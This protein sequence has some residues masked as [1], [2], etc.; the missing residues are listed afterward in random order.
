L[1]P[2][3]D[4][5]VSASGVRATLDWL[6]FELNQAADPKFREGQKWFF[7]EPVDPYGVRTVHL[8]RI[9][10]ELYKRVKGWKA[11][12]RNRLCTEMWKNGKLEESAAV[13]HLYRHFARECHECEFRLFER[14]L[15]RYVHTWAHCDGLST[16]LF[17]ASLRNEP[18]LISELADWTRSPNR[19]RRRAAAVSLLQEAKSG[20]NLEAILDIADR[21]A[22]DRDDMVEKGVGWLLKEAYPK[23]PAA[24]VR[25]LRQNRAR[26]SRTTLRYAA[27][28]MTPARRALVL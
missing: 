19:W 7:K 13:C 28:K 24:V 27:E 10:R 16:W 1:L 14:W 15:D 22:E 3:D 9:V 4:E 6:R 11:A 20:R 26:F 18:K 8:N 5:I 23:Q 12:D 2:G 25:F 21:L 17:A